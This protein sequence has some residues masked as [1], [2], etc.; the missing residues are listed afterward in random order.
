MA[1]A[2]CPAEYSV[3]ALADDETIEA[4]VHSNKVGRLDVASEREK[5]FMA[6]DLKR[7]Q[8]ILLGKT[9]KA[10]ILAAGEGRRLRPYTKDKPKCMVEIN[11]ESLLDRQ[12]SIMKS[13]G[14]EE[15]VIIGGYKEK[16]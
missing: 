14:V 8:S 7:A 12:I 15:I 16:H 1:L 10:I 9:T 2:G 11:G 3:S 5:D 13:N 4:I 6:S